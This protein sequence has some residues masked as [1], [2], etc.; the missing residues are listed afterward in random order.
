M[1]IISKKKK[2]MIDGQNQLNAIIVCV[3]VKLHL[4]QN[5]IG[6]Y[7][8]SQTTMCVCVFINFC[9][10]FVTFQSFHHQAQRDFDDIVFILKY[11]VYFKL[12][13]RYDSA[14]TLRVRT[15]S[16]YA[17]FSVCLTTILFEKCFVNF[18]KKRSNC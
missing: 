6:F 18:L 15:Q 3:C 13:R 8:L 14:C 1:T 5:A 2:K 11:F 16:I 10:C 4:I 12:Y 17:F 7:L 9:C